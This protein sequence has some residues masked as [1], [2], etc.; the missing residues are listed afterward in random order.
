MG[1]KRSSS[2]CAPRQEKRKPE[3]EILDP[4]DLLLEAISNGLDAGYAQIDDRDIERAPN[5][6]VWMLSPKYLN[7]KPY[8]KQIEDA[9]HIFTAACYFCSDTEYL[10]DIPVDEKLG[11]IRDR[12]V[13]MRYGKC[14]RCGRNAMEMRREWCLDP[15]NTFGGRI[16]PV[17]PNDIVALEGQRSGKSTKTAMFSTWVLHQY[18]MLPNPTKYFNLLENV[19]ALHSTF[20]SVTA[21]QAWENLWQPFSD[22]ID[23]S[24]WFRRY[25]K[26]LDDRGKELGIELWNKPDTYLWYGV[27]RLALS[28]APADQR[29]LRGRTRFIGAVDEIGWFG[30]SKDRTGTSRVRADGDGTVRALDRSLA[31]LRNNSIKKRKKGKNPPDAYLFTISSPSS[32]TDP[33][34]RR[35][36]KAERSLRMYYVKRETWNSNPNF[37]EESLREQ[38][39]DADER[40]F[41][42]DFA[43]NPPYSDDPWWDSLDALMELC[44]PK[45]Q[46]LWYGKPQ[47]VRDPTSQRTRYLTYKIE[48]MNTDKMTPRILAFDMGHKACSFSWVIA[49]YDKQED[50]VIVEDVGE[51]APNQELQERIHFGAMWDDLIKPLIENF[52]F[53]NIVWDRWESTR[54]VAD[55]RTKYKIRADQYSPGMKDGKNF[56]SDMLNGRI[57][58]PKPECAISELE[59]G[60]N[61]AMALKPKAHLLFQCLTA[62][63]G[64]GLPLK[65][66]GK[67]NNDDTL[68]AALLAQIYIRAN[69]DDYGRYQWRGA[70]C[71]GIGVGGRMAGGRGIPLGGVPIIG[72]G[73]RAIGVGPRG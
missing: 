72:I 47:I 24:P 1:K 12:T 58:F 10:L 23:S 15:A 26:W 33:I 27:K 14:P 69:A 56:K 20:V 39:G 70:R 16:R 2:D 49:R 19:G 48:K 37:T 53:L 71:V 61:V 73:G 29:T 22:F 30:A 25:H 36:K 52:L 62:R 31:T 7:I 68:R 65:P 63:N 3:G 42:C 46:H 9:I 21:E 6:V 17:P 28:F 34:M 66:H 38:E 5:A 43:V 57:V 4:T 40:D 8:P 13:L 45:D 18:L 64:N 59:V 55:I 44:S 35:Y 32:R 60:D 54:Y 50:T 41:Q 11:N 67:M 51:L